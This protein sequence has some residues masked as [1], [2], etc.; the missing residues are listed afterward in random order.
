[1]SGNILCCLGGHAFVKHAVT[2]RLGRVDLIHRLGQ[3]KMQVACVDI[4]QPALS[5]IRDRHNAVLS[6]CLG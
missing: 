4:H 5:E 3:A 1:M 2:Q 6:S